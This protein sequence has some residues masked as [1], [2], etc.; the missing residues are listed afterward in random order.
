VPYKRK[1][2]DYLFLTSPGNQSQCT[3][4]T[5]F[6]TANQD[7][8]CFGTAVAWDVSA[9]F[10][11]PDALSSESAGP[12][13]CAGATVWSPLY[14]RGARAGD[15]VGIIGVGGLGHLAIQFA[16]KMGMDAVVFSS[17]NSKEKEARDFG[18]SEFYAT[19]G[20]EKFEGITKLDVLL[21]TTNAVP[22]LSLLVI[23]ISAP[24]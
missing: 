18:A 22:N 17:T 23:S 15:R 7:Q 8:G 10:K 16:S 21:I 6:G 19:A 9:L 3:N 4:S 24:V 1:K 5:Y 11:I 12:L 13:M 2:S 20:V 14:D